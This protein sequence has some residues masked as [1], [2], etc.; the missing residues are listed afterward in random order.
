[1]KAITLF[2]T[3]LIDLFKPEA[4]VAAVRILERRGCTV[5]FP[6]G[7]TCCGQFSYNAGYPEQ[8]ARLARH[9]LETFEPN[10]HPLVALSGSCAAMVV[11]TYP[12]LLYED[13]LSR[14]G[15]SADAQQWKTRAETMARRICELSQWVCDHDSGINQRS[16]ADVRV[17]YHLGCHM[18]RILK[19]G[20]E[21]QDMMVRRGV[22]LIEPENADQCCGFGGTYSMTEPAISAALAD[23]KWEQV[24]KTGCIALTGAD[25]GCLLHLEGRASRL[26]DPSR[27]LYL[28]ELLDMA[29][30]GQLELLSEGKHRHGR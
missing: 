6:Q 4:A 29:E 25:M 24:H 10:P 5:N 11:D 1:M 7:Q 2:V 8:A 19:A 12:N 30:T 26:H 28:A 14:G 23:S 22:S 3:C 27:V 18:R 21:V 13:T 17:A 9:W 16:E 20:T 15:T